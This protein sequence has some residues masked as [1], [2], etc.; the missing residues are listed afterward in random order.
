MGI[1]PDGTSAKLKRWF[2]K[3]DS[4]NVLNAKFVGVGA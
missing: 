4:S 1:I 2:V 3:H